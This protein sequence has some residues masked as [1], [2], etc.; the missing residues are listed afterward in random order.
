MS[1]DGSRI[2]HRFWCALV[3]SVRW[4]I[5]SSLDPGR[6]AKAAALILDVGRRVKPFITPDDV[7][8]VSEIIRQLAGLSEIPYGGLGPPSH[9]YRSSL[10]LGPKSPWPPY[11]RSFHGQP[12][13]LALSPG[14]SKNVRP[15]EAARQ[16]RAVIFTDM[17][18][19]VHYRRTGESCA[20]GDPIS[21]VVTTTAVSPERTRTFHGHVSPAAA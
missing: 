1:V 8:R 9:R 14:H 4:C 20:S 13:A 21:A 3:L 18:S 7:P 5:P 2:E 19:N 12:L 10:P 15:T 16:R 17:R 11:C 6:S